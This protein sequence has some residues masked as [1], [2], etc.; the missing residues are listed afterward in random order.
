M[1]GLLHKQ[2]DPDEFSLSLVKTAQRNLVQSL[3]SVYN[4]LGVHVALVLVGGVVSPEQTVLNPKTIAE[5]TWQLYS[6]EQSSWELEIA[7]YE[8]G[9]QVL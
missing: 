6:Q 8:P 4:P 5:Q 1:S 2:P 9:Q 7:M 3:H